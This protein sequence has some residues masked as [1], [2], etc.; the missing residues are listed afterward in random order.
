MKSASKSLLR[1]FAVFAAILGAGALGLWFLSGQTEKIQIEEPPIAQDATQKTDNDDFHNFGGK[2]PQET[3]SLLIG[4]LEKDDLAL[5]AKYFVPEVREAE[6]QD[7]AK[8]QDLNLLAD[9]IEILK[10]IK[11]GRVIDDSH[12]RFEILDETG[13]SAVEIGLAKNKNGLWKI[14]SL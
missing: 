5:A 12:Y 7:L 13:E 4:A 11:S 9:M 8:L 6:S 10:K 2:T 1:A 14:I 3:L